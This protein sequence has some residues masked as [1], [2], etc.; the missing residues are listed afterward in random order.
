MADARVIF[1]K[2][3]ALAASVGGGL[4][5]GAVFNQVWKRIGSGEKPEPQ[6]LSQKTRD[7]LVAAAVQ[8][9]IFGIVKAGVDRATASG[10]K[11]VTHV[12]PE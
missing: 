5:A 11:K 4:L 7:V 10:F 9:L 3:L 12:S 6:D 8:G 1:Y 2:P